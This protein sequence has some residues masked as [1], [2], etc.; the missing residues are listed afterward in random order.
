[1]VNIIKRGISEELN[2]K[3]LD[4]FLKRIKQIKNTKE[5]NA[6]LSEFL[7]ADEQIMIKKR[8]AISILLKEGKRKKC[9]SEILDVSRATINSLQKESKTRK[10]N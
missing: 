10:Q 5:L 3:I 2:E 7:T 1:M 4:D 9:I 8:L 6:F